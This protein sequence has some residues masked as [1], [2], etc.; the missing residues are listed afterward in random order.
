M[1]LWH[2]TCM[3]KGTNDKGNTVDHGHD[4]KCLNEFETPY[5]PDR[6]E[7]IYCEKCYQKEVY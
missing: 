5:A 6:S 1:K 2:R 3:C 4:G 7:I